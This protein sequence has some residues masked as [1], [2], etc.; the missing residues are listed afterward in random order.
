MSN[1][2]STR[3]SPPLP[4]S[5]GCGLT[6]LAIPQSESVI[7][8]VGIEPRTANAEVLQN[9]E[10]SGGRWGCIRLL[11]RVFN[12]V[13]LPAARVNPTVAGEALAYGEQVEE[14]ILSS[15][16]NFGG[17]SIGVDTGS[18]QSVAGE[19]QNTTLSAQQ[20]LSSLVAILATGLCAVLVVF[21]K[22][23]IPILRDIDASDSA[24]LRS[25]IIQL[26]LYSSL[27][28][29]T[30]VLFSAAYMAKTPQ[31]PLWTRY[32]S[33]AFFLTAVLLGVGGIQ[34]FVLTMQD[35]ALP[36]SDILQMVFCGLFAAVYGLTI[37][38]PAMGEWALNALRILQFFRE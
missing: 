17:S 38:H 13:Q 3:H 35:A 29:S 19:D 4:D 16:S 26:L 22:T 37:F 10:D 34:M 25:L 32:C 7:T 31:A 23:V 24:H 18:Q 12:A 28:I 30:G 11:Q 27:V 2:P 9:D 6:S 14:F 21:V 1:I 8:R 5:D 15:T 36:V 33:V 20:R